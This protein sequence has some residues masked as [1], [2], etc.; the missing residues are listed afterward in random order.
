MPVYPLSTTSPG[1]IT[2]LLKEEWESYDAAI[3]KYDFMI[4]LECLCQ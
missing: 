1:K 4:L 3:N 2:Q